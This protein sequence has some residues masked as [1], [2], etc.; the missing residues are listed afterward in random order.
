MLRFYWPTEDGNTQHVSHARRVEIIVEK[1]ICFR[2]QHIENVVNNSLRAADKGI[3]TRHLFIQ[4]SL[5]HRL[6][7]KMFKYVAVDDNRVLVNLNKPPRVI[8]GQRCNSGR[9]NCDSLT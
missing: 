7:S 3:G 8:V 4:P 9:L 2:L 6:R 5:A 1:P